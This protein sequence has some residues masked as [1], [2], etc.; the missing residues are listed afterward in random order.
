MCHEPWE[1]DEH[2]I[3]M[4]SWLIASGRPPPETEMSDRSIIVYATNWCP[5][6]I[7]ARLFLRRHDVA[8]T[9]VN[10]DKDEEA[11]RYVREVNNGNRSVPTILFADGTVLVE[12]TN[13]ELGT[14][15][16]IAPD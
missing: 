9:W 12:P 4:N 14:I 7:R 16:G 3:R 11:E 15:I 2:S 13:K 6:C 8:F 1:R 5:D 10:I